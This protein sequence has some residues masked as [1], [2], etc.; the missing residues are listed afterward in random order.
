MVRN[1]LKRAFGRAAILASV[2]LG[3]NHLLSSEQA[4]AGG[5]SSEQAV[6]GGSEKQILNH[7][8]T[9]DIRTRIFRRTNG[10]MQFIDFEYPYRIMR[11]PVFQLRDWMHAMVGTPNWRFWRNAL[12]RCRKFRLN[13]R[14]RANRP[15]SKR[16]AYR[17][18]RDQQYR[19]TCRLPLRFFAC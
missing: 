8:P 12:L 17:P 9:H 3:C 14:D 5:S 10:F 7:G 6:A 16:F 4:V 15:W 1:K 13:L 11:R 18:A 19:R 2:S